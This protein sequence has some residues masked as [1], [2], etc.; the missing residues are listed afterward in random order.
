MRSRQLVPE[1]RSHSN[2]THLIGELFGKVDLHLIHHPVESGAAVFDVHLDHCA[3]LLRGIAR[4]NFFYIQ[5]RVVSSKLF[6]V[7]CPFITELGIE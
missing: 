7:D 2:T 3:G 5:G 1:R 4:R 6:L